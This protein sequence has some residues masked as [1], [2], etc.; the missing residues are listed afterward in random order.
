MVYIGCDPAFRQN[1]F[2]IAILD[3]N[4]ELQTKTFKKFI[5]FI[6]WVQNEM[7]QKSIVAIENSYLQNSTFD[8][9]GNK[10]VVA[11][12]SRNVGKNQ[13]VSQ[14][15]YELFTEYAA[16]VRNVSPK[17][18]GRKRDNALIIQLAKGQGWKVSK[19]RFNQDERD[20]IF[21]LNFAY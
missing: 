20:A 7:P 13:A 6:G 4:R 14:I 18:K 12:K 9:T 8:M 19:K 2:C 16:K 11:R 15:A 17:E 10:S 5:D 3:E 1:G 21:M